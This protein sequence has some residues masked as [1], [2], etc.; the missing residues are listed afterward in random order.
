LLSIFVE[1]GLGDKRRDTQKAQQFIDQ[2][3]QDYERR[4]Q[5]SERRLKEFKLKNLAALGGSENTLGTMSMLEGQASSVRIE[6]RAALQSRDALK[7]ELA[8]EE[9]VFVPD[10]ELA[11]RDDPAVAVPELDGRIEALKKNLDESLRTFTDQHPDVIGTRRVLA[12]LEKER[13]KQL[14]ARKAAQATRASARGNEP[15]RQNLDRNPVYQQLKLS[16]AE[17][18]ANLAALRGKADE[19]DSKLAQLRTTARL[20]PELEEELVQ[21]NRDYAVQKSNYDNLV[22]R[23]E[24][25]M[26]TSQLEQSSS[27]A[28][29]RIIEP[30]RVSNKPVAPNRMLLLAAAF[31]VSL[32]AGVLAS[33]VYSQ[34]F[35]VFHSVRGLKRATQRPVLGT[36][37]LQGIP[38]THRRKRMGHLAFFSG[39]IGLAATF[40]ATL[41]FLLLMSRAA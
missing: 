11:Q 19:I 29:F 16:L 33:L 36:V 30:P 35:P 32:G 23:R 3:I 37:S 15:R 12:E 25:A 1:S 41:A 13:D 10:S 34:L 8:G 22:T 17:A 14:E 31:A 39:L 7:R 40:G 21:L 4:L 9:P 38:A 27:V 24:A 20:R 18:E 28:D 6:L 5:E 26:M 2:Q